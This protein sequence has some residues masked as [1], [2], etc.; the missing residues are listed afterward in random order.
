M[1]AARFAR[2]PWTIVACAA[3][4]MLLGL[5]G[6]VRGDELSGQGDF[7]SRQLVWIA[8]SVPAMFAVTLVPYRV[9]RPWSYL[10]FAANLL[11]L[12]LVYAMPAKN[13]A[14]RWIPLGLFDFQPSETAKLTFIMALAHYL[15]HRRN[16]R[17][18][19][20]LLVPFLLTLVPV[21][22]ILR[23]PDLGTSLV[24]LPVLF[25]MLF[26][27]GARPRH[28]AFVGLL[29]T[30]TLPALW[31][32]MS[33]EQRSRVVSVFAQRD[34]GPAP[35]GDG[36]HLHQSKQVLALGG[37]WGSEF[38]GMPLDD[39]LAYHLPAARTD[40][41]FCL[42][43]ERWGLAGC[44]ATLAAYVVLFA[45][46]L[47]VAGGTREPFGRLLGVGIVALLATQTIINTGM[48]VGLMPI[49]G[50]TLPLMSYGGSSLLATCAA[51]GLLLNVGMRPGYEITPEP[52]RFASEP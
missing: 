29:G 30:A 34:G 7:F 47:R 2:I 36:Y 12:A 32:G 20:G 9:L 50:L 21:G 27:A 24:F 13:G 25:A 43:G 4:L 46:G 23:E 16:Y 40:F 44:A 11:L 5:S 26:A 17:R 18:L 45:Q 10:L 15:M 1:D 22:L 6:I 38:Q 49:T 3:A 52:F 42:V 51:L 35:P 8:L 48:T 37:G 19:T 33:A 28:L 39:A 14:H 31:M 41:I